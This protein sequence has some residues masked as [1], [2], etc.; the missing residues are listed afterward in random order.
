MSEPLRITYFLDV[1][2]QWCFA[3]DVSLDR[4]CELYRE[5][6]V[7]E[8]KIALVNNGLPFSP[9]PEAM[10]WV[11]ERSKSITGIET[12]AAWRR[13]GDV[14]LWINAA[15]EAARAMGQ[16]TARRHLAH[17]LLI[18]GRPIGTFESALA[19]AVEVTRLDSEALATKMRELE[20]TLRVTTEE[21]H[22]LPVKVVPCL[23]LQNAIGDKALL[24]GLYEF[25]TIERVI[26][27]MLRAAHGYK[28]FASTNS[29]MPT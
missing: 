2:S 22:T 4:V 13:P 26:A 15:A 18:E 1:I 20:P 16:P 24:S 5:R 8:W 29:P 23:V 12:N 28:V 11:Y 14:T 7:I 6:V 27:E 3:A 21:F 17:A 10:A 9:V 25:E 19:V